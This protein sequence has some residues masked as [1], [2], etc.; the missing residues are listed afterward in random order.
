MLAPMSSAAMPRIGAPPSDDALRSLLSHGTGPFGPRH[1]RYRLLLQPHVA[2]RERLPW[3]R[4]RLSAATHLDAY[5]AAAHLQRDIPV[6]V[7]A[8]DELGPLHEVCQHLRAGGLRMALI[9]RDRWL[10]ERLP[11][12]IVAMLALDADLARLRTDGGDTIDVRR[13]DLRAGAIGEIDRSADAALEIK[14]NRLGLAQVPARAGLADRFTPFIALDLLRTSSPRPLRIRSARFDFSCLGERK[15][16]AAARNVH[17]LAELLLPPDSLDDRFKRVPAFAAA[18]VGA[19]ALD[20]TVARR[21][22]DFTEYVL[23]RDDGA[24]APG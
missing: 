3:L 15:T 10:D 12:G 2:Y 6:C 9:D 20:V 19:P 4:A 1:A 8:G 22:A 5:T 7:G 11:I 13:T 14:K 23:L 24:R 18:G 16:I 21:E 17:L